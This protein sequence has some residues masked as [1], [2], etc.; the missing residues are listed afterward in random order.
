[1]D[2]VNIS[3]TRVSAGHGNITKDKGFPKEHSLKE[4]FERIKSDEFKAKTKKIRAIE[5]PKGEGK[6]AYAEAKRQLPFIT[7]AGTL[8][9]NENSAQALIQYSGVVCLDVELAHNPSWSLAKMIERFKG[10]LHINGWHKSGGYKGFAVYIYIAPDDTLDGS[11]PKWGRVSPAEHKHHHKAAVQYLRDHLDIDVDPNC[12][13]ELNRKRFLCHDPDAVLREAIPLE[14]ANLPPEEQLTKKKERRARSEPPHLEDLADVGAFEDEDVDAILGKLDPDMEYP[15]W[16]KVGM[17]IHT[18]YGG[19]DDGLDKFDEWSSGSTKYESRRCEEKWNT[20]GNYNGKPVT[21]ASYIPAKEGRDY[22]FKLPSWGKATPP[23][24]L[25][26]PNDESSFLERLGEL[27]ASTPDNLAAME[28]DIREA[29]FLLP[30]LA[31]TGQMTLINAAPNTGKTLVVLWLLSQR[32]RDKLPDDLTIFYINADDSFEGAAEKAR[33]MKNYGLKALIPGQAGFDVSVLNEIL[34]GAIKANAAGKIAV[35]LDTLKKF[36]DP[37]D[38]KESR[39]FCSLLRDFTM[40]GGTIIALA[41]TNKHKRADGTSVAEGVG[42]FMND[43]D[44]CYLLDEIEPSPE[45]VKLISFCNTKLRGPVSLRANFTY[46]SSEKKTWLERFD[47]VELCD[48][49]DVEKT[50]LGCKADETH[51]SDAEVIQ[52]LMGRLKDGSKARSELTQKDLEANSFSRRMREQV[53]DRYTERNPRIDHRHW[54][55]TK[56]EIRARIYSL[57]PDDVLE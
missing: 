55:E 10:G 31:L 24:S 40:G 11:K 17:A 46:D 33:R 51:Q 50:I 21:L 29:V 42:D 27:D 57:I 49:E 56:G 32:E 35:V 12:T 1:M 14:I 2:K 39:R 20:F 48:Q 25:H 30:Q 13:P 45:G 22:D 3:E 38:K 4:V 7:P 34:T 28:R 15:E 54:R 37:M 19:S 8:E 44:C 43:F 6:K 16:V 53:L 23:S 47:S 36:T 52:Y 18:N 26:L 41:H 5:D 9:R